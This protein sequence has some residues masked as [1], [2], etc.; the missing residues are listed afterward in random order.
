MESVL[1]P[2]GHR[3]FPEIPPFEGL[4]KCNCRMG[5]V[6]VDPGRILSSA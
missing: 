5:G 4:S 1:S 6:G 2:A 3:I